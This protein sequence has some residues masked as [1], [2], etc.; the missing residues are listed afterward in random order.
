MT[1]RALKREWGGKYV[2]QVSVIIMMIIIMER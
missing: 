1:I 2:D